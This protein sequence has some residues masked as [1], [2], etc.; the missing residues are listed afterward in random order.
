MTNHEI[1][2]LREALGMTT[3]QFADVIGVARITVNR[4]ESGESKPY[5]VFV[6][7]MGKMRIKVISG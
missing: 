3:Q 2:E 4:W 6:E 1:R 7:K 5:K